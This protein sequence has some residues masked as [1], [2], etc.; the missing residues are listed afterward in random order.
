MRIGTIFVAACIL[1][2][3]ILDLRADSPGTSALAF[4]KINPSARSAAMGGLSS[5]ISPQTALYNPAV[6]GWIEQREVTMQYVSYILDTKYSV[7]SFETPLNGKEVVSFSAGYLG[8]TGLDKTVYDQNTLLGYSEQGSFGY[9]GITLNAGYGRKLGRDWTAGASLKYAQ[10]SIDGN[11]E[12]GALL[13]AGCFYFPW[14]SEWQVSFGLT[15]LGAPINNFAPPSGFYAGAGKQIYPYL[16]WGIEGVTY[17]D[18][19]TELKTGFECNISH[20]FFIRG[21]YTHY[22]AEQNLGALPWVDLSGG[23]GLSLRNFTFDYAWVP[24]G[25]LSQTQRITLGYKF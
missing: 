13:S 22:L 24:Y 4:L 16:Y 14:N 23:V 12:G 10:Q 1:S 6:L 19:V 9:S 11:I 25:D 15:D 8:T 3:V 20:V 18:T 7:V 2:A 5:I 21:G 17:A